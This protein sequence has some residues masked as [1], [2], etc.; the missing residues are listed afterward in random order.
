VLAF[1]PVASYDEA[2]RVANNT[3]YGLSAGIV[4]RDMGTAMSFA[5]DVEAGIV[6]VN[7][8]TNGMAMN[9]P[10]GGVKMS[11]TQTYKEQAGDSM[12][13]FYTTDKTVYLSP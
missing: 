12:M 3:V 13:M 5:R 7:Q 4:T 2:V 6:K 9:A 10:F 1:I 8:S 11:S